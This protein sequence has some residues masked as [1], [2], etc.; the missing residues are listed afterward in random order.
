MI[1]LLYLDTE[2]F[3]WSC[4]NPDNINDALNQALTYILNYIQINV[5]NIAIY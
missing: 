2:L 1:L 5:I 3:S 4:S